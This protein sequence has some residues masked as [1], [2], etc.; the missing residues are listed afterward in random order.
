MSKTRLEKD[1]KA[2]VYCDEPYHDMTDAF[3]D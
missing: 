2:C 3:Y 1:Y